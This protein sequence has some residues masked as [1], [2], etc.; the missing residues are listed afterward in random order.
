MSGSN[1]RRQIEL[2]FL[3]F[4]STVLL[5]KFR[6]RAVSCVGTGDNPTDDTTPGTI[7]H[8]SGVLTVVA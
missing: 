5:H 2:V 8:K 3:L 6:R 7:A 1:R 4:E